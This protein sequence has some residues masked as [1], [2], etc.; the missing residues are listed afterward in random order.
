MCT[1][2]SLEPGLIPDDGDADGNLDT[3]PIQGWYTKS[4][5]EWRGPYDSKDPEYPSKCKRESKVECWDICASTVTVEPDDSSEKPDDSSENP[6]ASSKLSD[7]YFAT[8]NDEPGKP[9]VA[10]KG[11]NDYWFAKDVKYWDGFRRFRNRRR[12][13]KWDA[14]LELNAIA[15]KPIG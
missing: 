4:E 5:E 8:F 2:E 11:G 10:A 13:W 7:D 9:G 6:D 14:W 3:S 12:F 1:R 15:V